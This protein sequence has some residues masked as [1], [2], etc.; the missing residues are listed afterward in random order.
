[1]LINPPL[2]QMGVGVIPPTLPF[3]TL[4]PRFPS[5]VNAPPVM[6]PLGNPMFLP[7]MPVYRGRGRPPKAQQRLQSAM[8][9][10]AHMISLGNAV[11]QGQGLMDSS[12]VKIKHHQVNNNKASLSWE[13]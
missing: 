11:S 1:M 10:M 8:I 5:G 12:K 7:H 2:S 4:T 13:N 9:S 3:N 6:N